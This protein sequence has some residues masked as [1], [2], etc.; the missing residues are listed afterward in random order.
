MRVGEREVGEREREETQCKINI[1]EGIKIPKKQSAMKQENKKP[2]KL[3]IK[4][5]S[6]G[7]RWRKHFN[8]NKLFKI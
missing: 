3:Q 5:N 1:P 8:S 4:A 7:N 6:V 2:N